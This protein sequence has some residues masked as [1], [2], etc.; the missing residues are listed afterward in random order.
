LFFLRIH[1]IILSVFLIQEADVHLQNCVVVKRDVTVEDLPG[2]TATAAPPNLLI[3]IYSTSI[4]CGSC[5]IYQ[6]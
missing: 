4:D 3:S 6:M 1:N 5:I 2:T